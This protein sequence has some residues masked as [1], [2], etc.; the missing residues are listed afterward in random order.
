MLSGSKKT[1]ESYCK[2]LPPP[3][4]SY[5]AGG[6]G[7]GWEGYPLS[8]GGAFHPQEHP[9]GEMWALLEVLMYVVC[10]ALLFHKGAVPVSTSMLL[11]LLLSFL[12]SLLIVAAVRWIGS[13]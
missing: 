3:I 11:L 6:I 9:H 5:I 12:L 4:N 13:F 7:W 1:I 2:A 8:T 10:M